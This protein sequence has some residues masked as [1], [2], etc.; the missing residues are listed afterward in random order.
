[1]INVELEE[2][3]AA[4][5]VDAGL[6]EAIKKGIAAVK[7][8]YELKSE[9]GVELDQYNF[10]FNDKFGTLRLGNFKT[11]DDIL[12]FWKLYNEADNK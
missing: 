3:T 9:G 11:Q 12:D 7:G 6:I 2:F 1:M 4:E 8:T 5:A 10:I